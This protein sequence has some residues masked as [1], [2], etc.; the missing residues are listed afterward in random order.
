MSF[1]RS[2]VHRSHVT[3]PFWLL[4]AATVCTYPVDA[5]A[6]STCDPGDHSISSMPVAQAV[7]AAQL[8]FEARD[9]ACALRIASLQI[10]SL[11]A[12]AG[13]HGIDARFAWRELALLLVD[14]ESHPATYRLAMVK[15]AAATLARPADG[16]PKTEIKADVRFL[17]ASAE[18]FRQQKDIT[19]S[20]VSLQLAIELDQHQPEQLRALHWAELS[21]YPYS[22]ASRLGQ[23]GSLSRLAD[24]LAGDT[25]LAGLRPQLVEAI[26]SVNYAETGTRVEVERCQELLDLLTTLWDEE[27]DRCGPNWHWRPTLTA[28]LCFHEAGRDKEAKA[29]IETSLKFIDDISHENNRLGSLRLALLQL[30]NA[31]YQEHDPALTLAVANE[32]AALATQLDTPLA[33]EIRESLPKLLKRAAGVQRQ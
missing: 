32:I 31:K 30:F 12:A 16:V 29:N 13:R 8:R 6:Q 28:G 9:Y 27:C 1:P 15:A 14:D 2:A 20:L 21:N 22:D 33:K 25:V 5:L 7:E 24:T 17:L 18:A 23:I 10:E 19:S 11:S 26:L 4:F 3:A